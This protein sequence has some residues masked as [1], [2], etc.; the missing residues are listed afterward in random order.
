MKW[1]FVTL[2]FACE[3]VVWPLQRW[4]YFVCVD[5]SFSV[6]KW[7]SVLMSL[8]LGLLGCMHKCTLCFALFL[9]FRS[10]FNNRSGFPVSFVYCFITLFAIWLWMFV[11]LIVCGSRANNK[12][13]TILLC[14][15]FFLSYAILFCFGC[16]FDGV[17]LRRTIES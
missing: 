2:W 3:R 17:H 1:H 6:W 16:F 7:C 15:C 8:P 13:S 12:S 11:G 14:C 5:L 10:K 4:A 9:I